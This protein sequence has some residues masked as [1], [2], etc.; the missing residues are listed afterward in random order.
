MILRLLPGRAK[1]ALERMG[2]SGGVLAGGDEEGY[3]ATEEAGEG[4]ERAGNDSI[5]GERLFLLERAGM[6]GELPM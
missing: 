5:L 1:L 6:M 2:E 4:A 3:Q